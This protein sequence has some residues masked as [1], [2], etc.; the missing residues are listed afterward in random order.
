MSKSVRPYIA[1]VD[2]EKATQGDCF[3]CPV[4]HSVKRH[5]ILK[6]KTFGVGRLGIYVGNRKDYIYNRMSLDENPDIYFT[7]AGQEF[8]RQ[9]DH[10]YCVAPTHITLQDEQGKFL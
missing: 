1:W 9:F 3:D 10:S 6:G 5:G 8:V 4:Y 7:N 2:I